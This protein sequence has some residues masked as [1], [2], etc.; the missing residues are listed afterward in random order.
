[1]TKATNHRELLESSGSADFSA[2]SFV[3]MLPFG[4]A[5]LFFNSQSQE[6]TRRAGHD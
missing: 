6:M 1:M 4:L 2:L 3:M 5:E